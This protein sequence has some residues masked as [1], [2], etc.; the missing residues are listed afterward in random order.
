MDEQCL[1]PVDEHPEGLAPVVER[2]IR[3][4]LDRRRRE[5]AARGWADR[6]ADAAARFAG[7]MAFV[8]LH[9]AAV[10]AW[11]AVNR[12]WAPAVRPFDPSFVILATAASV[13][14]IFLSAFVLIN[15]N[16]MTAAADRRADLDLHVSLLAE[17]EVTRLVTLVAAVAAKLGLKEAGAPELAEL[18]KDVAP[19]KVLDRLA[20]AVNDRMTVVAVCDASAMGV[21]T[22]GRWAAKLAPE[23]WAALVAG[24]KE[25]VR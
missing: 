20:C 24:Q 1:P 17:H 10:L 3:A 4:L 15:Q 21:E 23:I 5:H 14:A 12:G 13:E 22:W 18:A 2:N 6:V 25:R 9:L 7:S 11:V 16:R 8:Y 19:E